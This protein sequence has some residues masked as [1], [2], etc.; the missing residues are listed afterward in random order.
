MFMASPMSAEKYF[1]EP[2]SV[3]V[4]EVV[5]HRHELITQPWS[6]EEWA[7]HIVKESAYPC[8]KWA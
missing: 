4:A 2:E 1:E 8:R 3:Y 6:E 5:Q 7:S